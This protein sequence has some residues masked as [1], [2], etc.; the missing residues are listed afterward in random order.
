MTFFYFRSFLPVPAITLN[1]KT[2]Y[3]VFARILSL[4]KSTAT[5]NEQ[6]TVCITYT[7]AFCM[8]HVSSLLQA[9]MSS[10]TDRLRPCM[11]AA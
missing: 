8:A 11:K 2:A 7:V 3:S 10:N 5:E 4:M 1:P 6:M 9:L